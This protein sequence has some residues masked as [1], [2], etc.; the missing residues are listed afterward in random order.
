MLAGIGILLGL[1]TGH[2]LWIIG[3]MLPAVGYEVYRTAGAST[4]WAAW[5]MLAI[6][7][8]LAVLVFVDVTIDLAAVLG[9]EETCVG[10][11]RVPLGDVELLGPVML[12]VV[13]VI[14]LTR[15]A[16]LDTRWL[17][18]VIAVSALVL[19]YLLNS[20][21]FAEIVGS[22]A[23]LS[24]MCSTASTS[25]CTEARSSPCSGPMARARPPRPRSSRGSGPGPAA[26]SPSWART[27][28]PPV[29]T[30]APASQR[31]LVIRGRV[32]RRGRVWGDGE[33]ACGCTNGRAIFSR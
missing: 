29:R 4:R 18:V 3:F 5:A 26:R 21:V 31:R 30:G 7:L 8:A 28:R 25:T 23:A 24:P 19:V 16:G 1:L 15:T 12:V 17:A 13:A 2:P 32:Q 22:Q 10:G 11:Y 9:Q 6:V 14:L 27:R 20:E 33:T